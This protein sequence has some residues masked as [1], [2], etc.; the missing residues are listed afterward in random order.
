[1]AKRRK[2][3]A[4]SPEAL[5]EIAAELSRAPAQSRSHAAPIAQVAA[6]VAAA[7]PATDHATQLAR[8]REGADAE[9]WRAADA[10]GRV[11]R[12]LPIASVDLDHVV[13]DRFVSE[14]EAM[15]E[16]KA[17][18]SASGQRLPVEVVALEGGRYG[19]IS[20]WRRITALAEL[21]AETGQAAEVLALVR[22][23]REAASVYASMVE[24]NEIRA[25]LSPYERGR[26]AAVAAGQGAFAAIDEAVEVI[27][28]AASKAKRSKIRGFALV[29]E[30]MGDLLAF[31]A[32]I[33][34]KQ[35]LLLA[36]ALRDGQADRLRAALAETAASPEAEWARLA[37]AMAP[38][39][40]EP[41]KGGRPRKLPPLVRES[42]PSGGALEF[43]WSA[44]GLVIKAQGINLP[45]ADFDR[46]IA[47]LRR[48][49]RAE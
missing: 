24:E 22:S 19:L 9:A 25:A 32:A 46:M 17:S 6:E 29:H 36:Q 34:E 26:I 40:A 16:L 49:G 13:R 27:F 21:A 14:P 18:L 45:R 41:Q 30:V 7:R 5:A 10:Q 47:E 28:A 38:P 12:M 33:S 43:G 44:E 48:L 8:L 2:L 3:E 39:K 31:P 1:M 42:L 15:A 4:P 35:G 11:L 37:A 23:G 20:G